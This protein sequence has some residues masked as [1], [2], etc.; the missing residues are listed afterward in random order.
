MDRHR[1]EINGETRLVGII[2][3]PVAHTMSPI[4]Q[5]AA[6]RALEMNWRYVPLPVRPA[7]IGAA[8]AGIRALGFRGVN[9]TV[10]HKE[11]AIPFL[12]ALGDAASAIGAVN[13]VVV[14]EDGTLFGENTDALGF[15]EDLQANGVKVSGRQALV[16]GAG[17]AARAVVYVLLSL[18]AE[19]CI[20][21]RSPERARRLAEEMTAKVSGKV[22]AGGLGEIAERAPW[23]ELVVQTTQVGM[24]PATDAS[25]WPDDVPFRPNQ[26]LYDVIYK[27]EETKIMKQARAG[28]ARAFNGLGMLLRQGMAAFR[29]WTGRTPPL[30]VMET[31]VRLGWR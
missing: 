27:P 28:G 6:F 2:G 16:L 21:N 30:A 20:L 29:L 19:V 17:G 14:R 1:W 9:L 24:W 11:A 18:G 10:P 25:V 12:D 26:V 22:C 5:N 7:D 3:W 15:K 8:L 31:A 13:T 4:M 23:A